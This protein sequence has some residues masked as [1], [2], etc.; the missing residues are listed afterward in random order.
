MTPAL[1]RIGTGPVVG[2]LR[3]AQ[4]SEP[5]RQAGADG[6]AQ[7]TDLFRSAN[8]RHKFLP[9]P[10][11]GRGAGGEGRSAMGPPNKKNPPDESRKTDTHLT[12]SEFTDFLTDP[13]QF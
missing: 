5:V 11:S 7:S 1:P 12:D 2:D 9:S 10:S 6:A 8:H 13:D 4:S 3:V